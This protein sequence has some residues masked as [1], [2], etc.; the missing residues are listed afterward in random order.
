[1]SSWDAY[2]FAHS[3]SSLRDI[4]RAQPTFS[5]SVRH[6]SFAL[7]RDAQCTRAMYASW[8]DSRE[9]STRRS[10]YNHVTLRIASNG[11]F[12]VTLTSGRDTPVFFIVTERTTLQLV[13]VSMSCERRRSGP[14]GGP[15]DEWAAVGKELGGLH[16]FSD[17]VASRPVS[18]RCVVSKLSLSVFRSLL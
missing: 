7:D 9:Y 2:C 17:K 6:T 15:G 18:L 3:H 16:V 13:P 12:S 1:M 5:R 8:T 11:Q 10:V 14:R 4:R